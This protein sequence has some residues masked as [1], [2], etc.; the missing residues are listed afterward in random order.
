MF[1]LGGSIDQHLC[2]ECEA[3]DAEPTLSSVNT[4]AVTQT[5]KRTAIYEERLRINAFA[6]SSTASD[7]V[8]FVSSSAPASVRRS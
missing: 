1:V 7:R 2:I 5:R 3:V 4:H 8:C 6:E